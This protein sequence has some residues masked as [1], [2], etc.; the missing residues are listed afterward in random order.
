MVLTATSG[1]TPLI[2]SAGHVQLLFHQ[3]EIKGRTI[4][5]AIGNEEHMHNCFRKH[6]RMETARMK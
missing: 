5:M 3:R 1:T 2:A 6:S 4:R